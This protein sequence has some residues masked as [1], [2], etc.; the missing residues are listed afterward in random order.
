MKLNRKTGIYHVDAIGSPPGKIFLA[1]K[2]NKIAD[3]VR[4]RRDTTGEFILEIIHFGGTFD[5]LV[6]RQRM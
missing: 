3:E 6:V 2:Y 5:G 1:K 4:A